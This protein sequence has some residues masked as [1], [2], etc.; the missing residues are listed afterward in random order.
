MSMFVVFVCTLLLLATGLRYADP[1]FLYIFQFLGAVAP[2]FNETCGGGIGIGEDLDPE[3][4]VEL[5]L[6]ILTYG[7]VTACQD[8]N[9]W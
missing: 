8:C 2:G 6:P 5:P 1:V 4:T 3:G 9:V 7:C